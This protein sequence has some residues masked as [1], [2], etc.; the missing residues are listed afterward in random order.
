MSYKEGSKEVTKSIKVM[1]EEENIFHEI[2]AGGVK[3]TAQLVPSE[4]AIDFMEKL[5]KIGE[6]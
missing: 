1:P 6:R 3:I 2:A 4:P 5:N